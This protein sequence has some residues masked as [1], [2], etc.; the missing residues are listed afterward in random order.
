MGTYYRYF[1]AASR[2][3]PRQTVINGDGAVFEA[4]LKQN[5]VIAHG[6]VHWNDDA[7]QRGVRVFQEF[8]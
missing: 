6:R 1:D 7:F 4:D 3:I 8:L 5:P 2:I